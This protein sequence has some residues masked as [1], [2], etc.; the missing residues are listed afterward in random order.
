MLKRLVALLM[1]FVLLLTDSGWKLFAHTCLKSKHTH[2]SVY[3][4]EHCCGEQKTGCSVEAAGCCDVKSALLKN[5]VD[6]EVVTS[7]FERV[8][9]ACH[10]PAR[11][12]LM[13]CFTENTKPFF[14]ADS[15]PPLFKSSFRFTSVIRC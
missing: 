3:A 12:I 11:I 14:L 5:K 8:V 1:M 10:T 9:T 6:S 4:P 15:S 13:C 7:F 2:Y